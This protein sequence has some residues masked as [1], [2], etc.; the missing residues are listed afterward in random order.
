MR[1]EQEIR[2]RIAKLHWQWLAT[3]SNRTDPESYRMH[4]LGTM[5]AEI[6][7]LKWVLGLEV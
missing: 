3:S 2:D 5:S 6:T 1:T 7:A 4:K